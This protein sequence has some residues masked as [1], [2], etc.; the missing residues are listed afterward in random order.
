MKSSHEL[1]L[2]SKSVLLLY[3]R[4]HLRAKATRNRRYTTISQLEYQ[5]I[6]NTQEDI[7]NLIDGILRATEAHC[8]ECNGIGEYMN[9]E[10]FT[11]PALA[12]LKPTPCEY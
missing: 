12:G 8:P 9:D 3:L 1:S 7:A 6:A 4:R 10:C 5:T 11:N 2:L